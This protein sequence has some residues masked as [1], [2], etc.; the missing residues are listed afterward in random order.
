MKGVKFFLYGKFEWICV[1]ILYYCV[2]IVIINN[3]FENFFIY[4]IFIFILKVYVKILD[5]Y[6]KK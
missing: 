6:E 4:Y 5:V 1:Y 2:D 3:L